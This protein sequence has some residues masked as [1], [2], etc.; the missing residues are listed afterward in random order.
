MSGQYSQIP[1]MSSWQPGPMQQ[2]RPQR[3][4]NM[5]NALPPSRPGRARRIDDARTH[6]Q[7]P[8]QA[9]LLGDPNA[10]AAQQPKIV[11]AQ[12]LSDMAK[13][14]GMCGAISKDSDV[15]TLKAEHGDPTKPTVRHEQR[16][17]GGPQDGR[18]FAW[19]RG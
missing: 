11:N 7:M 5:T 4:R 16:Q 1:H 10:Q 17:V 9:S 18:C 12:E 3:A 19:W 15:C 2:K 13:K 8:T 14:L 6:V